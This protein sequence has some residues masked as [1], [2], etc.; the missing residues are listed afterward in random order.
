MQRARSLGIA[1]QSVNVI[2]GG[3]FPIPPDPEHAA[4]SNA[5]F[6]PAPTPEAHLEQYWQEYGSFVLVEPREIHG[7]CRAREMIQKYQ[8]YK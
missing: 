1:N 7:V 2:P 5:S 6:T 3:F 4:F 8:T